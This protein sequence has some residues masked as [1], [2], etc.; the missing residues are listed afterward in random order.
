MKKRVLHIIYSLVTGGAEESLVKLVANDNLNSHIILIL[1][2]GGEI[3]L[4]KLKNKNIKI[5]SLYLNKNIFLY[6]FNLYKILQIIKKERINL[7]HSWMYISDLISSIVGLISNKKVIWC[8]RNSTLKIGS[9]SIYS[10]FSRLICIPL[11]YI[12]PKKIIYCSESAKL[13]HE[14]LGYNKKIGGT[15]F[16]GIN[17]EIFKPLSKRILNNKPIK[18]GMPARFDKQKNHILLLEAIR[19][20]NLLKVNHSEVQFVFAGRNINKKNLEAIYKYNFKEISHFIKIIG[21]VANMTKFYNDV[22]FCIVCSSYGEAF[23][24]VIAESMACGTPC[25]STIIGDSKLI[26]NKNGWL[27]KSF[28]KV[29][30]AKKIMSLIK[31][32]NDKYILKSISGR[33]RIKTNYNLISMIKK[34]Q[35][36]YF[37]L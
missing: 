21:E 35:N 36:I 23:P 10:L 7:I 26:I 4:N 29:D 27:L 9:T 15:V 8:V 32:K 13:V 3:L 34:F 6:I 25:I 31:I 16:N 20:L 22:D 18:I 2:N 37:Y 11:S 28:D 12:C 5:Y 24:N 30:L 33:E 14:N 17:C 19:E 1:T